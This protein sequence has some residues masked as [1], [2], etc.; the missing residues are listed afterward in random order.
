MGHTILV[1]DIPIAVTRK[2]IKHVRLRVHPPDGRVTMSAPIA[3]RAQVVEAFAATRL[4]WIRRWQGRVRGQARETPSRFVPG[5]SHYLWGR[6]H[7]LSVVEHDDR[8]GAI[9]DDRGITLFIQ[10]GS[11]TSRRADV[12]HAWHKSILHETLPPLIRNW[13]QRLNVHLKGYYLRRMKT[14]W[15][16]CNYRTRHIRLNTELVTKPSHLLDYVMAH[17]MVHL[18]VPNHGTRFVALMNEHYPSWRDARAELNESYQGRPDVTGLSA[19]VD[20]DE[21]LWRDRECQET[22]LAPE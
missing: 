22:R 5:E 3:A 9:L 18:I 13:E 8:Q 16:T 19:A 14:R 10:P 12:I 21:V 1:G 15:G 17:E 4:E 7:L 20:S 6:R 11:D 2:R